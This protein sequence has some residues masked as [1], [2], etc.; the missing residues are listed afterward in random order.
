MKVTEN[1]AT[2][3]QPHDS[4]VDFSISRHGECRIDSPMTGVR[5]VG[6]EERVLCPS[7]LA[8]W[9]R[10]HTPGVDPPSMEAAGRLQ[11]TV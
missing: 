3:A 5:F 1:A 10:W 9:K 7:T 4:G 6:D 11:V 8:D 2:D